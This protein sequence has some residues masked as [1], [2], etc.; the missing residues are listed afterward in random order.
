[1]LTTWL[2]YFLLLSET[3]STLPRLKRLDVID[4]VRNATLVGDVAGVQP[5]EDPCPYRQ[6]P[7]AVRGCRLIFVPGHV[8][9]DACSRKRSTIQSRERARRS[10]FQPDDPHRTA[11]AMRARRAG[12]RAETL[13]LRARRGAANLRLPPRRAR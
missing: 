9:F 11:R 1:G 7:G 10:K 8:R 3:D 6:G 4:D 12:S 2:T 5:L 13:R